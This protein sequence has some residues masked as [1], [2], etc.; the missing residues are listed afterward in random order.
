MQEA[1]MEYPPGW[2]CELVILRLEYYLLNTVPRVEALA[3]AEHVEACEPCAHRLVLL[4]PAAGE[5]RG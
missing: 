5:R 3:I 2:T 4:R 1:F